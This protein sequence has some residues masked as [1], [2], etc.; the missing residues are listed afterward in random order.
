M[1]SV[2][3]LSLGGS[4]ELSAIDRHWYGGLESS[5]WLAMVRASLMAAKEVTHI[6]CIKRRSV[7]LLGT[8]IEY[9]PS[10]LMKT[11]LQRTLA[12]I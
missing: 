11:I 6:L 12:V 4:A 7:M 3:T 1:G 8:T 2:C 9:N 5:G 10:N